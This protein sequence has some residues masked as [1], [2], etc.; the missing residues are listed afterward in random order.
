M[1]GKPR[2][3]SDRSSVLF[4][5]ARRGT[6]ARLVQ[7]V[8]SAGV[9]VRACATMIELCE[10]LIAQPGSIAV[11]VIEPGI[12]SQAKIRQV[13][14][15]LRRR[16]LLLLPRASLDELCATIFDG[17]GD[18]GLLPITKAELLTR[19]EHRLR[20][21][22]KGRTQL[23]HPDVAIDTPWPHGARMLDTHPPMSPREYALFEYLAGREGEVVS[24]ADILAA[25]WGK[26]GNAV[27]RS[28]VVDVYVCYL[29]TKLSTIA[30]SLR[31]DTVPGSGYR[32]QSD[33]STR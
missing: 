6:V 12:E 23:G 31:I 25:V 14:A 32:L 30:P 5:G 33:D 28:N 19:I 15:D 18:F 27:H 13:R 9:A 24:R 4:W 26:H 11:L 7:G 29:R 22:R 8:G 1:P 10:S 17:Y 20:Q 2:P 16:I 21:A 3:V